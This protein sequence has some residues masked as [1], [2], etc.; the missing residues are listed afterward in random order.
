M[1]RERKDGR[2][3]ERVDLGKKREASKPT[4]EAHM[5]FPASFK[6]VRDELPGQTMLGE[7]CEQRFFSLGDEGLDPVREESLCEVQVLLA[8][9]DLRHFEIAVGDQNDAR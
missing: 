6:V 1:I 4:I 3:Q 2:L 8:P 9:K 7:G 5:V